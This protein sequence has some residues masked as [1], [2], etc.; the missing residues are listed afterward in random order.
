MWPKIVS[1]FCVGMGMYG[2][3]R[4]YRANRNSKVPQH[5]LLSTRIKSSIMNGLLYSIPIYNLN[6]F[7]RLLNRIEIGHKQL[8]K[9]LFREQYTEIDGSVLYETF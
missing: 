9:T 8:D 7:V 1:T 6:E 2:S 5:Q 4:G 3:S